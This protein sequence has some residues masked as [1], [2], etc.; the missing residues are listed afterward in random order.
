M[1]LWNAHALV[2]KYGLHVAHYA[3]P[4]QRS[5]RGLY[6]GGEDPSDLGSARVNDGGHLPDAISELAVRARLEG[7]L[8]HSRLSGH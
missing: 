6:R 7:Q 3:V 8:Q 4:Q 1:G 5:V 2:D